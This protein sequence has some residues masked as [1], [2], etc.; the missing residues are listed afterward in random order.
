MEQG[1]WSAEAEGGGLNSFQ[2][3]AIREHPPPASTHTGSRPPLEA[4]CFCPYLPKAPTPHPWS[5]PALEAV[6]PWG[7]D[8]CA[9]HHTPG[10]TG[11]F[12]P[13]GC[14]GLGGQT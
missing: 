13:S 5:F 10:G 4:F 1:A 2:R 3:G 7:H 11:A 8:P 9:P 12:L 6:S 14:Q